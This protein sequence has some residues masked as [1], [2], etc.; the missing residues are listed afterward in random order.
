MLSATDLGS[1]IDSRLTRSAFRLELLD[2]YD[3]DSDGDDF[4]RF[5][6]GETAPTPERKRPWLQRLRQDA[7]QGI[8]NHRVHVLRRPLTDYLRYEAEWGYAYNAAAGED[9]G[10]L[11]TTDQAPPDGLVDHDFWLIDD[12]YA[13][14]MYYSDL[15]EFI[16]AEPAPDLLNTYRQARDVA[17]AA[18]EP[19]ALWWANHPEEHRGTRAA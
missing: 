7:A 8:L 3:V 12:Q 17:I 16:G 18:A 1:Y 2:Q 4:R 10:I 15:G 6:S 11:D 19:F 5:V 14:R 9:I 13:I